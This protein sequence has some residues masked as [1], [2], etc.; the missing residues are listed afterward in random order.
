[1]ASLSGVDVRLI[2]PGKPDSKLTYW[3]TLSYLSELMDAGVKV[4]LYQKGFNHSKIITI[5][6]SFAAIGSANMDTRSFEHNF[7]ITALFYDEDIASQL[8]DQFR[9]DMKSSRFMRRHR[10]EKRNFVRKLFEGLARLLS[11]LL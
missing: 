7:E 1:V 4:Y 5:D 6:G 10:W 9:T 2:L 11:P 3:S 8:E